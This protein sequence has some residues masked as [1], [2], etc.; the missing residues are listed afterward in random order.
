M[1]FDLTDDQRDVAEGVRMLCAGRLRLDDV[2]QIERIGRLDR[3]GWRELAQAGVF[4]LRVPEEAGGVGL[5]M[6][7]SAL[8]F[9]ELGRHLVPGPLV[10]TE[11]AT[12]CGL[13]AADAEHV[14]GVVDRSAAPIMVEYFDD[15][16]R[17]L[18]LDPAGIW[19]V[20]PADVAVERIKRPLDP[21]TPMCRVTGPLPSGEQ[22]GDAAASCQLWLE[23]AVLTSAFL[24]GAAQAATDLAVDYAKQREQFG[25]PIAGFQ[26]VKHLLADMQARTTAA[27]AAVYAAA[28]TLDDPSVGDV[29]RAVAAAKITAGQ[30]AVHAGRDGIQVHGGMGFTWEVPAHLYLKRAQLLNTTFGT[31][32]THAVLLAERL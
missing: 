20:A 26:A 15:L 32:D 31:P 25:R 5:G 14:V 13:V 18:V 9:E 30:A 2:R 12:V 21:L 24:V 11:L 8:V 4:G 7:E 23:G 29:A 19:S 1:A 27:Q 22:V 3:G 16:D 10:G 17:I 6:V 28:A